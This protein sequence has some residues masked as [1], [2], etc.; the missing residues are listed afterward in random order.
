MAN[1]G[2]IKNFVAEGEI[3]PLRIVALGSAD[4]RVKAAA[5]GAA[6]LGVTVEHIT[7]QDGER[8]DVILDGIAEI[9]AGGTLARGALVGA[10]AAGVA[11][12]VEDVEVAV[13]TALV[14]AVNGDVFRVLLK[15]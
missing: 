9:K 13:G 14:D 3:L 5:T 4:G 2:L 6:C 8:V 15:K 10:G 12:A 1:P 11:V 7:A